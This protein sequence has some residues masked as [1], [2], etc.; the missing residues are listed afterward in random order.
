[1]E[2]KILLN[3]T[4]IIFSITTLALILATILYF[5]LKPKKHIEKYETGEKRKKYFTKKGIK[6]GLEKS[7]YKTRQLNK[8]KKYINGI[9]EGECITYYPN[10]NIYIQA[11]YSKGELKGE[12]K[13]FE[14]NGKIKL[15][16]QY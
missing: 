3:N 2:E 8:I 15:I 1:M 7:F 14:P 9:P 10:G 4:I 11:H 6:T 5:I 13:V 16:K 12:Y